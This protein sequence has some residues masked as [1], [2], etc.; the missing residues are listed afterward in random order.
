DSCERGTDY[1]VDRITEITGKK[2]HH[3]KANIKLLRNLTHVF[4][5][6]KDI[7]G[8]LHFAAYKMVGESVQRPLMYYSNN[9]STLT[10]VLYCMREFNIPNLIFS[11][12]SSAYGNITKLPVTEDSPVVEQTSPYGRTKYFGEKI[13]QDMLAVHPFRA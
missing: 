8:V 5:E 4:S 6:Q 13:I 7:A 1:V 10:N 2:F 12:S 9:I 3:Y 11:S